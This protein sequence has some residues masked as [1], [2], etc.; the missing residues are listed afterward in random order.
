MN[1]RNFLTCVALTPLFSNE[2]LANDDVYLS[3]KEWELLVSVN[4]RLKRL[5]SYIGYAN[6]NLISLN[7]A[8]FYGRN[9]YKIGAFTKDEIAFIEQL[10]G[11]DPSKYGFYGK[12]TCSNINNRISRKEVVKIPRT[13]HYLFNG[14]AQEDYA[15]L[16]ADVG[17][18]LILT[19]GV[20]NVVKQLSLYTNK[21]YNCG[22]NMTK[23]SNHLAPPAYSYHT[24]RDFDVGKKGW[25]HKNFTADFA[26]TYEFKKMKKLNYIS[27]RYKKNNI[28]GVRFEPWHVEVI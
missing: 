18:T 6:F 1:R 2:L 17:D 15:N 26:S 12:Q 21:I 11:E 8:L 16:I 3:L 9:Y 19:S 24:I 4:S 25:G 14:K 7:D 20:R 10:F 27:M 5:K 13:G 22:G 28:D 23:A